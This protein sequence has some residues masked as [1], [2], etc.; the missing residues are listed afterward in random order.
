MIDLDAPGIINRQSFRN[1]HTWY[2]NSST[3]QW[4]GSLLLTLLTLL[5]VLAWRGEDQG[6]L[7]GSNRDRTETS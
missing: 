1:L 7:F 5:T 4:A 6:A 3:V 2:L